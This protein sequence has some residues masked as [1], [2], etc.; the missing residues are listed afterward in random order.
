MEPRRD[1]PGGVG[2]LCVE[3]IL[4]AAPPSRIGNGYAAGFM[5]DGES[6]TRRVRI[7]GAAIESV[8]AAIPLL[9]CRQ[10]VR[11]PFEQHTIRA[12]P[13]QS[14]QLVRAFL[15]I[16]RRGCGEPS[17]RAFGARFRV[18]CKTRMAVKPNGAQGDCCSCHS[19][20]RLRRPL[21]HRQPV[22]IGLLPQD[23]VPRIDRGCKVGRNSRGVGRQQLIAVAHGRI[24]DVGV[25]NGLV[26]A[27]EEV[28]V[29][30]GVS[31]RGGVVQWDAVLARGPHRH[32]RQYLLM[33]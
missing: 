8:P 9:P 19:A 3:Q 16:V 27:G 21:V 30:R 32:C 6:L 1:V 29:P 18:R 31:A 26:E 5:Q 11:Q 2:S 20:I 14:I 17:G 7:A 25:L 10:L 23:N 15:G 13:E 33:A 22:P 12:R 4:N 28:E 24:D